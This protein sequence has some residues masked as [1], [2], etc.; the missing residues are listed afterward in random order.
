MHSMTPFAVFFLRQMFLSTPRD[1][2]EAARIDGASYFS[3]F[4]RDDSA[5]A[6]GI[7]RHAG[8]PDD[9]VD[10]E[11]V[12]LALPDWARRRRSRDRGR[13]SMRFARSSKPDLPIGPA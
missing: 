8:N 2:E 4:F 12:L 1:V 10:L 3:I 9:G 5:D 11:R 7:A 13:Q 6:Q